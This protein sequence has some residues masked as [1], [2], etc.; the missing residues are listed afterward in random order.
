MQPLK[1]E[2]LLTDGPLLKKKVMLTPILNYTEMNQEKLNDFNDEFYTQLSTDTFIIQ[3][4][5][6]PWP[7]DMTKG[8][9]PFSRIIA[10][11]LMNKAKEQGINIVIMSVLYPIDITTQKSGILFFRKEK[12]EAVISI[13]VHALDSS[14][15]TLLVSNLE[16]KKI[17]LP[18]VIP[19]GQGTGISLDETWF[20]EVVSSLLQDQARKIQNTL[21]QIPWTGRLSLTEKGTLRIH[22]GR[23]VGILKG[24]VFEVFAEGEPVRS[25]NDRDQFTF[26]PTVGDIKT[27]EVMQDYSIAVPL[28]GNSFKDG[29]IIRITRH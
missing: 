28:S 13:M 9:P 3:K 21:N 7:S 10:P 26:G 15:H 11:T 22:G 2:I 25:L 14:T 27:I 29:Q 5:D 23:D 6:E 19:D 8:L 1:N 20:Y 4:V 17:K 18:Y 16:S 12:S 24:S